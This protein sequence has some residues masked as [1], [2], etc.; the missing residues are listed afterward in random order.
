MYI[1]FG[2]TLVFKEGEKNVNR[3]L[4]VFKLP[5]LDVLQKNEELLELLTFE[6]V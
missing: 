5:S 1:S 4:L 3:F 2:A 6:H